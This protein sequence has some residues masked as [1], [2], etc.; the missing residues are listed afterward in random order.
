MG[1]GTNQIPATTNQPFT[2]FPTD[3]NNLPS[4]SFVVP[5]LCNDGHDIC[6]PLNNSVRQYDSWVQTNL[7]AYKNWAVNNNSLLIV[8][9]DEDEFTSTNKIATVFYGANV[10]T[11]VYAQTINHYNVLRTIEEA[12]RL[13]THAGAAASATPIGYCWT[14]PPGNFAESAASRGKNLVAPEEQIRIYPSPAS[15]NIS[16]KLNTIGKNKILSWEVIDISGM[17]LLQGVRL[18]QDYE[19]ILNIATN[20]LENG[21]Y[22][23]RVYNGDQVMMKRFII[24]R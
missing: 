24:H 3:Y 15:N 6:P 18:S 22:F 23:M 11:G 9:Y 21:I 5:D 13:T 17:K 7:D 16:V 12:F 10:A 19:T 1:T 8:T 14:T 20:K 4:V 2:A